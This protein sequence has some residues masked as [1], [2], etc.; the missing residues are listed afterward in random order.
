MMMMMIKTCQ[1]WRFCDCCWE[2]EIGFWHLY[3]RHS[4]NWATFPD[5]R[6]NSLLWSPLVCSHRFSS[7]S[8]RDLC[9]QWMG[10]H[11][12]CLANKAQ[13]FPNMLDSQE[14]QRQWLPLQ[15]KSDRLFN[16]VKIIYSFRIKGTSEVTAFYKDFGPSTH[17]SWLWYKFA[18]CIACIWPSFPWL[19]YKFAMCI[20]CIWPSFRHPKRR[21]ENPL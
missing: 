5:P 3:V 14:P 11:F 7:H 15:Q 4:I 8:C 20:V 12:A 17:F 18:T 10:L 16:T 19:W 2:P 1:P 13:F 9:D 21:Q 6:V